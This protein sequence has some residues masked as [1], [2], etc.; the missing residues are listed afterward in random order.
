M[1][2]PLEGIQVNP[3]PQPEGWGIGRQTDAASFRVR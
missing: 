1:T 2:L 3:A